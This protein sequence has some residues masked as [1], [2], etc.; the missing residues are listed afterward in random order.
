[1]PKIKGVADH[2][3]KDLMEDL[4]RNQGMRA[5]S[6]IQYL[7]EHDLPTVSYKALGKYGQRNWTDKED[8]EDIE[9]EDLDY[10]L[11]EASTLGTIT[12]ISLSKTGYNISIA[13]KLPEEEVNI[14]KNVSK[15]ST[16][17]SK[18]SK[19]KSG[20][21]THVVIPDTQ[22]EP[23]RPMDHLWWAS[24]YINEHVHN[25]IVRIIHL[26]DH[27][28]MGS[29]SSYDRGKGYMEGRRYVADIS[30]GNDA[31]K[32][33]NCELVDRE[34]DKH[35]LFGNH[36]NRINKA[37]ENDIQLDGLLTTEHCDTL[38]WERHKFLDIVDLD[39]IAYSHYFYH[40]NTSRPYGGEI[41]G[42]LKTIGR[43]FV[44]GHQQGLKFAARYIREKQQIGIAA[45]SF[46]SHEEH[47][48]GPQG[49]GYWR[50]IIILHD[51]ED[52]SCENPQFVSIDKLQR[53]YE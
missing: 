28:N 20:N 22:I 26:G 11:Q 9:I 10:K 3:N 52:G 43:S 39:G 25:D 4:W 15:V 33:L 7:E 17:P 48:M 41:E 29:L 2:P 12:R 31:F 45:G 50:G 16:R 27:W 35:F 30:S 36:E 24:A 44:M 21:V 51:V 32:T 8:M 49:T 40:P 6:I 37:I 19:S 5:K 1:M 34:F 47:Y 18:K 13:P 42:R 23:G 14:L 38:D 53:M 46:Y